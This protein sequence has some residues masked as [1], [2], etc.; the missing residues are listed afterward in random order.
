MAAADLQLILQTAQ[1]GVAHILRLNEG[2][3]L[4][5]I[6]DTPLSPGIG[7]LLNGAQAWTAQTTPLPGAVLAI[8]DQHRD[9]IHRQAQIADKAQQNFQLFGV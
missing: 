1:P 2:C 5:Q 7:L 3:R 4:L 6:V 8:A 9:H